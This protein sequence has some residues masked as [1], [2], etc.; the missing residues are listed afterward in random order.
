L[1]TDWGGERISDLAKMAFSGLEEG[2][3][4][5]LKDMSTRLRKVSTESFESIGKGKEGK[6]FFLF[7]KNF[8][9]AMKKASPH[10]S[11]ILDIAGVFLQILDALGVLEPIMM[12]FNGVLQI[13]GGTVMQTL[14]PAIQHLADVLF[15]DEMMGLWILLGYIIGVMLAPMLNTFASVLKAL[16][17]IL[18]P[19]I[20]LLG[21]QMVITVV[22]LT[23]AIGLLILG[24]LLPLMMT[25]YAVG[26][27]IAAIIGFFTGTDAI[28]DWNKIMLPVL[29]GMAQGMADIITMG[30][31]GYVGPSSGGTVVIL[32]EGGEGEYVVPE[33]KMSGIG[34]N[35]EKLLWATEDNGDKLDIL[36]NVTRSQGRL[37]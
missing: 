22:L 28:G 13:I 6:G 14:A 25:F 33:S 7:G 18:M 31:G 19:L 9:K 2:T 20:F 24:G 32:G 3:I 30:T 36:I 26:L 23:K 35:N 37:K 29:G 17:P 34:S 10:L 5:A 12:L 16:L 15:S 4:K 1:S 8:N 27:V 11:L 21:G